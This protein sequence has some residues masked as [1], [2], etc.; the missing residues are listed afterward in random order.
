MI[1]EPRDAAQLVVAG[2]ASTGADAPSGRRGRLVWSV[3]TA[4]SARWPIAPLPGKRMASKRHGEAAADGTLEYR[5]G[6]ATLGLLQDY[7]C[8]F[9][10]TDT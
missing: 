8:V 6:N 1:D 5:R 7:L 10:R 9:A 4:V 2:A 3:R